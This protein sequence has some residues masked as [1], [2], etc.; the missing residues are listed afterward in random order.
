MRNPDKPSSDN[1]ILHPL[2][3]MNNAS[4]KKMTKEQI[5]Y[6]KIIESRTSAKSY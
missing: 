1:Q 5:P 3:G 6:P 4:M 2:S